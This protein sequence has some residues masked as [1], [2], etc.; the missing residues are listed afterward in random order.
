MNKKLDV[1]SMYRPAEQMNI[2]K[3][4]KEKNAYYIEGIA[5]SEHVDASGEIIVQSGID[6]SYALKSG[7]FNLDHKNDPES[8]L[9]NPESI[10]QTKINGVPATIV[11]GMLYGKKKIVKDLIENVKA[12]KSAN[13]KRKLGFSIEGQVLARDPRN[14]KIITK[15][16]VLNISLT[17]NPCNTEATVELVKNILNNID[18]VEKKYDYKE[19]E[20]ETSSGKKGKYVL[21]MIDSKGDKHVY[22]H[23]SRE[24]MM[25]Q[26]AAIEIQ[27]AKK[28]YKAM[29]KEYEENMEIEVSQKYSDLHMS[30]HQA[31]LIVEYGM[32]LKKLL[33]IVPE[34][35]DLPEWVQSKLVLAADYL[36]NSY[37]YL[38]RDVKEQLGMIA[39]SYKMNKEVVTEGDEDI[40]VDEYTA[41]EDEAAY[42]T[43]TNPLTFHDM[44]TVK[45][46][47]EG[48]LAPLAEQSLEGKKEDDDEELEDESMD[49]EELA[50]EDWSLSP[51]EMKMLVERIIAEYGK[52]LSDEKIMALLHKLL[53][54]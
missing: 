6:W 13:A 27:S 46:D 9:G 3:S 38:E 41:R 22:C 29:K 1:F 51:S 54:K 32:Q 44:G 16:K 48:S 7:V 49:G 23:T 28:G 35:I 36:H 21:T 31:D 12:M 2:V 4:D 5:T 43:A 18:N 8:I 15:S 26:V 17:H 25:D 34:D 42:D 20:C 39:E 10:S 14:P 11:R 50:S 33:Q 53:N 24:Q 30:Q 37:H 40:N 19:K 47:E 45:K 52:E